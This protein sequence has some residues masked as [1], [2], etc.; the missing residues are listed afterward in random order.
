MPELPEVEALARLLRPRL[1]GQRVVA[2][3]IFRPL[4]FRNLLTEQDPAAALVGR[5]VADVQRR[6]K[7][8]VCSFAGGLSL[9][10]HFMLA[11][12][13]EPCAPD[14]RPRTRDYY[15]LAFAD[16]SALR[17]HDLK[18]MGK[19][20]LTDDLG[21]V[22]GLADL[23]PDALDPALTLEG[24]LERLR[25]HRGEIKG[26]LTRER[27]VSG[28]G[29]AYADEI[30]FVAGIYPFRKANRLS[31]QELQGLYAAMRQVLEERV[32]LAAE[33][34]AEGANMHQ[35]EGMLV[36]GRAG[37][38]CPRCGAPISEISVGRRPTHF[39]RQCQ[40]GLLLRN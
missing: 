26:V 7:F 36:H 23:G 38:P 6:S 21:R 4:V 10:V 8:L 37:E 19:T 34:L 33:A 39:C 24:F 27:A 28:I 11:G 25:P 2:L 22:P 35:R 3:E 18:G 5:A 17:Y 16:G 1:V 14:A 30:L 29:N 32:T 9:V 31:R 20:Y 13:L 40:P 15:R 12:G